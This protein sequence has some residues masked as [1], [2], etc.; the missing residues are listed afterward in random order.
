MDK[1][2]NLVEN[3][4]EKNRDKRTCG[5]WVDIRKGELIDLIM[6]LRIL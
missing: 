5:C 3:Y 6:R 4:N 2:D 1:D